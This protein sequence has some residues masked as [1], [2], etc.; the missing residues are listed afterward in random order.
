MSTREIFEKSKNVVEEKENVQ[1]TKSDIRR[2]FMAQAMAENKR[3]DEIGRAMNDVRELEKDVDGSKSMENEELLRELSD[4]ALDSNLEKVTIAG[5]EFAFKNPKVIEAIKQLGN[6]SVFEEL[7]QTEQRNAKAYALKQEFVRHISSNA[8]LIK[9]AK[10]FDGDMKRALE[11]QRTRIEL[12]DTVD[13]DANSNARTW[14]E[15]LE[16]ADGYYSLRDHEIKVDGHV[17]M[18]TDRYRS[19]VVR[20]EIA[21]ASTRGD[22]RITD[23][24]RRILQQS[25]ESTKIGDANYYDS[26]GNFLGLKQSY[27]MD[28]DYLGNDTERLARKQQ[29]D[30]DMERLGVK[31]YG[32]EFTQ[33]HYE[34]IFEEYS[35]GTL[36]I[37]AEEFIETT[38][39]DLEEYKKIFNEVADNSTHENVEDA[40]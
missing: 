33:E 11:E 15:G 35:K 4:K 24:A 18:M 22:M 8:Y 21:H 5:V 37:G 38:K 29:L 17:F 39:Q 14:P 36:S 9:L 12:T 25:Y 40:V 10:E 23:N 34:R 3:M 6:S 2:G 26:K 32:E 1:E 16:N 13:I 30:L 7:S 27:G 19:D 20:H 28:D 31:K